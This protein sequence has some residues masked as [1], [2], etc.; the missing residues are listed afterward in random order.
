MSKLSKLLA[1]MLEKQE[2]PDDIT[3]ATD[4]DPVDLI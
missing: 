3:V 4:I 1:E 2:W